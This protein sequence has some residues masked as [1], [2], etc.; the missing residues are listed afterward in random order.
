MLSLGID[1]G[2]FHTLAVSV[3]GSTL[4][5]PPRSVPSAAL[6]AKP[7]PIVG[8]D[9]IQQ[10]DLPYRLLQAPKLHMGTND[11]EPGLLRGIIQRLAE[12]A[13]KDLALHPDRPLVI[14]VPPGW[15]LDQC[16][17]LEDALMAVAPKVR[18]LHEPV[19]LLVA[20]WYLARVHPDAGIRAKL[21]SFQEIVVCDWGA[22]T[23]DL[24]AVKTNGD[25]RRPEFLC[26]GEHTDRIW[27]G[28]SI[29][30][31]AVEAY[32]GAGHILRTDSERTALLLQQQWAGMEASP[33]SLA[34]LEA[35][36]SKRRQNAAFAIQS[37]T[38][39]L[40]AKCT[41]PSRVLFVMHGGPL[42]STELRREFSEALET[43]GISRDRQVHIGNDFA[44]AVVPRV[45]NLRRES[46]VALGAALF[47]AYGQALPE[48][49]YRIKL[50]DGFGQ[51]SSSLRL[52][53]TPNTKGIQPINPPYTGVD[54]IVEVQQ[55]SAGVETPMRK[56][57][58]LHVRENAVVLYRIADA[59][60]GFARIEAV[61][62]RNLPT[63]KPFADAISATVVMP[64][65]STRF[66]LD[67]GSKS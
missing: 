49:E 20:A 58:A 19:A 12:Q 17:V 63:P 1:I 34:G 35:F 13:L 31:S 57:L 39:Q 32:L 27:G 47:S 30:R 66:Q 61:E 45:A 25:L 29:A 59:G 28:T 10:L 23:V 14:T 41:S 16:T 21:S 36:V 3:D 67:F 8:Y 11:V 38:R 7:V 56:E 64:E 62:A 54:Y 51:I 15:T 40:L 33:V 60:V 42:E 53:I 48:F 37:V 22:G 50:R 9:A 24:A 5:V 43:V 44:E 65:S 6:L 55:M 18:F 26:V 46:L 52:A 4:T 2:T